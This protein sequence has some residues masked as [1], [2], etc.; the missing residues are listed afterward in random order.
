MSGFNFL[1][2][3]FALTKDENNRCRFVNDDIEEEWFKVVQ[4]RKVRSLKSFYKER[5]D[6]YASFLEGLCLEVRRRGYWI[7]RSFSRTY[8]LLHCS[9]SQFRFPP[10]LILQ[11]EKG[12]IDDMVEAM[13]GAKFEEVLQWKK[14][15]LKDHKDR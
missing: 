5:P 11:P 8:V 3:I 9:N 12:S 10:F 13:E 4:E 14:E 2:K 6:Y 15:V 1:C 7:F